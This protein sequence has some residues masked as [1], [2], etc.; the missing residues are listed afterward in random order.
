M[1]DSLTSPF[2]LALTL[3]PH[4]HPG[5]HL[6]RSHRASP[7]RSHRRNQAVLH[8]TP[9]RPPL[10]AATA[11]PSTGPNARKSAAPRWPA[12]AAAAG[13]SGGSGDGD[14]RDGG[15]GSAGGSTRRETSAE[16][17]A[18]AHRPSTPHTTATWTSGGTHT[19]THARTHAHTHRHTHALGYVH[20]YTFQGAAP[21]EWTQHF[22]LS[23]GQ[24]HCVYCV[25]LHAPQPDSPF[26]SEAC[27][28]A[29]S[30]AASQARCH[31]L[32]TV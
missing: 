25:A 3:S 2:T 24:P 7:S 28:A 18:E 23:D 31:T 6:F 5:P 27:A 32:C 20:F 9:I 1:T 22:A 30:C 10:L 26:C 8:D 13:S 14:G 16:R 11:N 19:H 21:R 4:A 29:F 17:W 12:A 15:D